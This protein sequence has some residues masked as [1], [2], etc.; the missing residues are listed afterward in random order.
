MN[1]KCLLVD[2][3]NMSGNLLHS[4]YITNAIT[5]TGKIS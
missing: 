1:D 3:V 5:N 2:F 4:K